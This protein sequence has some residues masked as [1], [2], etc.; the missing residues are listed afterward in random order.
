MQM[1]LIQRI[2]GLEQ[3]VAPKTYGG[4][5]ESTYTLSNVASWFNSLYNTS[6]QA[7]NVE[8]AMKLSTYYACIRNISEDTAK[9]PFETFVIDENGNKTF[10]RHRASSLLNK[11]PS[12]LYTPFTFRQTMTENALRFG[13]GFAFIQR[14]ADGK[15]TQLV[16]IDP[17]YVTVQIVDQRLYYIINDVKS[18]VNGTF[19]EDNIF[20][21]RAMGD[22]FVGKSILQYGTESIGAGLAVQSYSSS[23]FGSGATMTGVLEVPG[24]VKDENTANSI[25]D[26]FNKS[27][28]SENGTNNGV[29]LL[30]S[31]AKFTKISAQPNEAQMVEAKEFTVADIAKWFR[32]PLS[33]LQ[34]GST[35]SSNLEQLNIEYVTDCLM[36]WFVKWEQEVERKLFR[37]DEMDILDAKFNVA[38]LMRGDMQSTAEYLKTLK[39]AGFITSNDGRRFVGLNTIKETFADQIYSPV[40]MIPAE[41]EDEFWA[42]KDQSQASTKGTDS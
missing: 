42:N 23:F 14:D 15:P 10:I 5:Q 12:N 27:Y 34:A 22:G 31:G 6:G 7:V 4:L 13:N 35:G 36:P 16:L 28:K 1:G 25:K 33:K 29:A 26:S 41:K 2:F 24:V 3:R 8:T 18:G 30:H 20:H 40:N 38:M 9:V 21:I 37:F 19:S 32:M 17:T 39:Y 11:F